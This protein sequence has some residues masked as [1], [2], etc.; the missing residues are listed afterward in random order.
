MVEL[1]QVVDRYGNK[2][3][4]KDRE[5][6]HRDGDWHETFQCWFVERINE[7]VYI[8]L[9]LRSNTKKDFPSLYDITAAGH[10]LSGETPED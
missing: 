8:H 1:I 3:N 4:V 6:V 10:L 7:E 2:L 5:D 9:Q